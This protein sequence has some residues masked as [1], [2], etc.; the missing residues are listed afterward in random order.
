MRRRVASHKNP[1]VSANTSTLVG[2]ETRVVV[3][4][5]TM[6]CLFLNPGHA[7]AGPTFQTFLAAQDRRKTGNE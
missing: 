4:M 3:V 7:E 2:Y 5:F 6:I 1:T